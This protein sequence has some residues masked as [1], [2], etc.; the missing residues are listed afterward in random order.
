MDRRFT[1]VATTALLLSGSISMTAQNAASEFEV[2][3]IKRNATA[4]G[5]SLP[6][7]SPGRLSIA[8]VTLRDLI[9]GA[10]RSP[11]TEVIIEGPGWVDTDLFEVEARTRDGAP[12]EMAML[13]QLL[14]ERFN[15]RVRRERR[16][17][18]V[19]DLVLADG[20]R[21]RGPQLTRSTCTPAGHD[22]PTAGRAG[23]PGP[24]A[25]GQPP[26]PTC[27][28]LRVGAGPTIIGEGVTMSE[29]AEYLAGFPVVNRVVH[30]RTGLDGLFDFRI[31]WAPGG[32]AVEP[33]AGPDLFAALRDQLGLRLER[34]M[35]LIDVVIV[36]HAERLTEN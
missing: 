8:A 9:G 14:S 5:R 21:E 12:V 1:V 34:T 33:G 36:D 27:G 4:R 31:R 11:G 3:S 18:P 2:A 22:V 10:Y 30:D 26:Q 6:Q 15:L 29:L 7:L 19:F 24:D 16:E 35:A 25:A 17:R 32:P 28:R 13:Q 20:S 23:R